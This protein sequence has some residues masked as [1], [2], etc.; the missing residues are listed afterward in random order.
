MLRQVVTKCQCRLFIRGVPLT[1]VYCPVYEIIEKGKHY[2]IM[3]LAI[4]I[5]RYDVFI[6]W[7]GWMVCRVMTGLPGRRGAAC[8]YCDLRWLQGQ[9]SITP[10]ILQVVSW[11]ITS[12]SSHSAPSAILLRLPRPYIFATNTPMNSLI[13][14]FCNFI[15]S[16]K[17][18]W[19]CLVDWCWH[20]MSFEL[21]S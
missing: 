5:R 19:F 9:V 13:L 21:F 14:G 16:A 11:D 12:S 8:S 4:I 15:L 10:D 1:S 6:F 17:R 20:G 2:K 7:S 18:C 3:Q